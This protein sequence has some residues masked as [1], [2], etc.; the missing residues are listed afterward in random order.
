MP[1][2]PPR[3]EPGAS[4]PRR[5]IRCHDN[6][7]DRTGPEK[8]RH[9]TRTPACGGLGAASAEGRPMPRAVLGAWAGSGSDKDYLA[10]I[11]LRLF[12]GC[13]LTTLRAG[14]ALTSIIS[15]GL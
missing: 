1:V 3:R 8:I 2:A 12:R 14:L 10:I 7:I 6:G 9:A 13:A 4:A 15:P 5:V 11:S